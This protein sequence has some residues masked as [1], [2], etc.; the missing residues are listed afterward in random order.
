[1]ILQLGLVIGIVVGVIFLLFA[2]F[3]FAFWLRSRPVTRAHPD[4]GIAPSLVGR[5]GD[6]VLKS[7]TDLLP[8]TSDFP[9]SASEWNEFYRRERD[10]NGGRI[11]TS[12]SDYGRAWESAK[13]EDKIS[14]MSRTE[15]AAMRALRPTPKASFT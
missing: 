14:N 12:D 2:G 4:A 10:K 13:V 11:P 9:R 6:S 1:M 5:K 8:A 7:S 3:A 15:S